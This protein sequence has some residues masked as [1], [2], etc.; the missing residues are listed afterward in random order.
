MVDFL[1]ANLAW[2]LVALGMSVILWATVALQ[3][4][5]DV[6]TFVGGVP[7]DLRDMPSGL[8]ATS[9]VL[10]V[11]LDVR[12]PLDALARLGPSSFHAYIE[13]GGA[14]PGVKEFLIRV[15]AN[16]R[17][18][19]IDK[20]TPERSTLR[21]EAIKKIDV[22]VRLNV[23]DN[24]PFGYVTKEAHATPSQVTIA[25]P[26]GQVDQVT[27][28]VIE[29]KLDQVNAS[30]SKPMRPVPENKDGEQVSDV[31]LTPENVLVEVPIEQQLT[32]KAVPVAP[33]LAGSVALGFQIIGIQV[34]P[35]VVTVLGDPTTLSGTPFL[36]T[37]PIDVTGATADI[38]A[39]SELS[40]PSGVSP[41]LRQPITVRIYISPVQ[42]NKVVR[43]APQIKGLGGKLK[44]EL[45][46]NTVDVTISGPMQLLTTIGPQDVQASV[47]VTGISGGTRLVTVT[48]TVASALRMDAVS[49]SQLSVTVLPQ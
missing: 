18:V 11:D 31:T 5:P 10:P 28:A 8:V 40:L 15:E 22:P 3:L 37:K 12:A 45:S 48:V 9:P 4:N 47:D 7:V 46:P 41:V 19:M 24:P 42:G 23:V 27:D 34:D 1:K 32:Y 14:T 43:V 20:I 6:S 25:G 29:I 44:A 13:L 36:S 21:L 17:R 16:D 49:P 2:M 30:I 26:E 38:V 39:N 35:T 33:Q